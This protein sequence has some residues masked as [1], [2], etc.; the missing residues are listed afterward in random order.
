MEAFC[1]QAAVS[2]KE[3][4]SSENGKNFKEPKGQARKPKSRKNT[5]DGKID[6]LGLGN[7]PQGNR[8]N[9]AAR[10]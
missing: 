3:T 8:Q 4:I 6:E 2:W 7:K 5:T 1:R 9:E 10:Q